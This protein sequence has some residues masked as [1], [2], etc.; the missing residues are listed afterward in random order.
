MSFGQKLAKELPGKRT[1]SCILGVLFRAVILPERM[2]AVPRLTWTRVTPRCRELARDD[3]RL[4]APYGNNPVGYNTSSK[5]KTEQY[6]R[7]HS[8]NS[9]KALPTPLGSF[10]CRLRF[11]GCNVFDVSCHMYIIITIRR[12]ETIPKLKMPPARSPYGSRTGGAALQQF[13]VASVT[14]RSPGEPSWRRRPGRSRS[15][16][17]RRADRSLP[18]RRSGRTHHRPSRVRAP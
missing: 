10:R 8:S 17:T 3:W 9:K 4:Q 14:R 18:G 13:R 11:L 12:C 1:K 6:H 15:G 2:R 16:G 5:V 7:A